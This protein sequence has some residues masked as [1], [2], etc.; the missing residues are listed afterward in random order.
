MKCLSNS[1][2]QPRESLCSSSTVAYLLHDFF[3]RMS[4]FAVC[5]SFLRVGFVRV[6]HDLLGQYE[7]RE[8]SLQQYVVTFACS[9]TVPANAALMLL[10]IHSLGA[11]TREMAY[12]PRAHKTNRK[13]SV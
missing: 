5:R 6:S 8:L 3:R 7:R 1:I 9:A 11:C 10:S 12:R 13:S 2:R 4:V